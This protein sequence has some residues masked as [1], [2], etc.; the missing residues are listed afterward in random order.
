[1]A[2]DITYD[3]AV[4]R[5]VPRVDRGEQIN[6]GVILSCPDTEFLDAR[7]E[8]DETV[9]L[10]IDPTVDLTAVRANLD[11]IREICRG[12][13]AAG[14]IG[15]MPARGRFRWLV[16]PRSTIVQPS[17]VH[18]GKTSDPAACLEQLMDRIVRR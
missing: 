4:I 12:G 8:L 16:S 18:T 5:V 9:L 13:A 7:I 15:L 3:Y 14:P 11:A 2:A 10:A 17:P 1:V 6:V